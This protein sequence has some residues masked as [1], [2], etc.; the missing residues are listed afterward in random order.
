MCEGV[1]IDD[2]GSGTWHA[3][4]VLDADPRFL[5]VPLVIGLCARHCEEHPIA[6]DPPKRMSTSRPKAESRTGH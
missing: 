5:L 6:R 3:Q 4:G 2:P 1:R